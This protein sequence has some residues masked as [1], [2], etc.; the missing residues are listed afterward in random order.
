MRNTTEPRYYDYY[1]QLSYQD[2]CA[3]LAA[4]TLETDFS[5]SEKQYTEHNARQ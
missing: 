2:F 3:R 5:I 1:C 4:G